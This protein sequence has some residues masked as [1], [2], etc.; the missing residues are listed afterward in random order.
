MLETRSD[1]LSQHM[2]KE[3]AT[4]GG[5]AAVD[6]IGYRLVRSFEEEAVRLIYGGYGG[7]IKALA[8]ADAG[9]V[10]SR[11]AEIPSLRLLTERPRHLVPPPFQSWNDV[12]NAL[13]DRLAARVQEEAG[14]DLAR[15]TWGQ[16]NRSAIHHPLALAVPALGLLTDPPDVP[17]PGDTPLPRVAAPGYGSTE[18]FVVSPGHEGDGIFEM[19]VGEASNPMSQYFLAGHSDWVEGRPSPFLPL[20]PRWK[21]I[22]TP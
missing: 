18:R 12:M 19:P 15:F 7:I 3:V 22:L 9:P 10:T 6:S 8:G 11:R 1:P 2:L 20:A 13:H 17:L 16:R 4:W 21:L 14:G 5:A